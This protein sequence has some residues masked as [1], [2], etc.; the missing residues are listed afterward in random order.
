MKHKLIVWI[1]VLVL[2]VGSASATCVVVFDKAAYQPAE[3]IIATMVCDNKNE[4]NIIYTLTWTNTT[5]T[6]ETDNGITP[7]KK[8]IAFFETFVIPSSYGGS[9]ITATL[10]GINLE[11]SDTA[12]VTGT[13]VNLLI[14]N[15]ASFSPEAYL[16]RGFAVDFEVMDYNGKYVDNAKCSVYSTDVFDAPLQECTALKNSVSLHGRAICSGLIDPKALKENLNYLAKIRC[17]CGTG[18]NKCFDEDGVDIEKKSGETAYPFLV[19]PWLSSVNTIT[20]ESSY[21]LQDGFVNV[22]VNVT[23]L[24]TERIPLDINYNFRCSETGFNNATDRDVV[25]FFREFRGI[26]ANTT[27]NQCAL[28]PIVNIKPNQNKVVKCYA[29][30]DIGVISGDLEKYPITYHTTSSEFTITSNSSVEEVQ[31]NM[32]AIIIGMI[33]IAC[34][35]GWLGWTQ[36]GMALKVFSYGVSLIEMVNIAIL[37]YMST[38]GK[39]YTQILYINSVILII[40]GFLIGFIALLFLAIKLINVNDSGE[41]ETPKWMDEEE[42][43]W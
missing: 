27:Q 25:S 17:S 16:G 9:D 19:T 29:A 11:G 4:E 7:N 37:S 23:N 36:D 41:G 32:I 42:V 6:L 21:T 35:F 12:S 18:D 14:I 8:K 38:A 22:C 39:D 10:T 20:D 28:L 34:F 15:N 26:S 33:A 1:L 40:L 24:G 13:A 3:T 2:L 5:A 31:N 43:K 30:T